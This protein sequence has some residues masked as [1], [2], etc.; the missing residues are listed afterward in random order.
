LRW[1]GSGLLTIS[2]MSAER[3]ACDHDQLLSVKFH[4]RN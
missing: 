1:A 4:N 3:L 2:L